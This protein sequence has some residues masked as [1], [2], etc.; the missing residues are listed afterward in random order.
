MISRRVCD[1]SD[2]RCSRVAGRTM[3][4]FVVLGALHSRSER[5][6]VI[7]KPDARY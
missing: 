4:P 7:Q 1:Q 2:N 5:D 6:T 3:C